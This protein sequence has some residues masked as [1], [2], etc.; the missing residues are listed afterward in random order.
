LTDSEIIATLQVQNQAQVQQIT[1]LEEKVMSLL[2]LLQKQGVNRAAVRK[3]SHNSS[4]PPS[5]DLV[6]RTKSLREPT[7]RKSGGQPGHPGSTLTM[8][9]TPNTITPLKSE[10]CSRCGQALATATFVLKARRQVLELPP[11][12]PLYE[13]FRQYS[14]QCPTCQHQQVAAFPPGVTAPIQYGSSVAA[15]ISYL[16]VYQ[17]VPFKR[18][19]NLFRAVFCLPLSQG[20]I[21][22]L[23]EHSAQQCQGVY[24]AIKEQLAQSEVV[25]ADETGAKVKGKKWWI[26]TWQNALN[27]FIVASDNRGSKT[28]D[29]VWPDGLPTATLVSDR[30][31]AHLKMAAKHQL[32]LAHLLR[33]VIF[34]SE[35]EAHLFATDFK[36]FLLS[37]F[38][39]CKTLGIEQQ[40]CVLD[41]PRSVV[42]EN[43]LNRLLSLVVDKATH[44]QTATFQ[45]SI[46]KYRNYLLPGLY[47]LDIPPDNNGSERAIRTI[48]VKQ[49]VSGQFRSGQDTF[50]VIRSV[51]DT[52]LKRQVE[53]LPCLNQILK[54]QPV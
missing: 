48:K 45:A 37:V 34:L 50:C 30:W 51:I 39:L 15:L 16:S 20:T 44:P 29:E 14:C 21:G 12:Q 25:G 49:K 35:S 31:A 19:Q 53:V 2:Q 5:T 17:Y 24:E 43:E 40:A 7:I 27:T 4:L 22:N 1:V 18:L 33:E 8:S 11:I 32:C 54:L 26:W 47:H 3:D 41:S 36:A 23:L 10:F 46:L 9:S 52:L 28:I 38:T 6:P 13:E 42:L